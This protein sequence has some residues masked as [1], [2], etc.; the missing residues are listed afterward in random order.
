[1]KTDPDM[2]PAQEKQLNEK[3]R[4]FNETYDILPP[5]R[6]LRSANGASKEIINKNLIKKQATKIFPKILERTRKKG[7]MIK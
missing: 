5:I 2:E 7:S 1:M 6:D 3:I 4:H